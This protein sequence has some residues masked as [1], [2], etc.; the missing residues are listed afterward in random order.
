[1]AGMVRFHPGDRSRL[2]YSFRGHRGRKG[3][4]KGFTWQDYRDLI[5]RAHNQLNGPIVPVRDNLRTHLMPQMKDFIA[6][7][8]AW[9]TVFHFPYR[10]RP[11]PD[12]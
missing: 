11:D 8:E 10:H 2:I 3:E 9:L 12:S 6:A 7:N 1:M 5:V 4:P